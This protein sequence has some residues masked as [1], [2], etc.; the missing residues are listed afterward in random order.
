MSNIK[1]MTLGAMLLAIYTVLFLFYYYGLISG[2][3]SFILPIPFILFRKVIKNL[4]YT[5]VFFISA[6]VLGW[7]F[8]SLFGLITTII[9]SLTGL[10]LTIFN[11]KK[12]SK[13]FSIFVA[14]IIF[15]LLWGLIPLLVYRISI[16]EVL[17]KI[18]NSCM[19][20]ISNLNFLSDSNYIYLN[21]DSLH[22][23]VLLVITMGLVTSYISLSFSNII[24][25][26]LL[27]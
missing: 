19:E 10:S 16:I 8:G 14:S 1:K 22:L 25:D 2:I 26:K 9:Y 21:N 5:I 13:I 20:I 3:V 27:N 7:I 4:K 12:L 24:L 18:L 15:T 23:G 17:A 6:L 11:D